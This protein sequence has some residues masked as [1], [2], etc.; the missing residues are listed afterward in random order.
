MAEF[1]TAYEKLIKNEGGYVDDPDDLGGETYKGIARKFHPEWDGWINIDLLKQHKSFPANLKKDD[2]LQWMIPRFYELKYWHKIRGNQIENQSVAEYI[3]DF[4][5][6]AGVIN[7]S[8]MT[9]LAVKAK[10]DGVIGANT[11]KKLNAV[12]TELFKLRCF[13]VRVAKRANSCRKRPKNK[14]Y[15][16]GWIIRDLEG[17]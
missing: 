6:N 8:R 3:F 5:V 13:A 2:E 7:G 9:Q 1:K 11:L 12:D 16:L 17:L 14:K 15:L 4:S 10:V